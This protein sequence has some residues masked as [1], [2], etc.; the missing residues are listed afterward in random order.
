[1]VERKL[2]LSDINALKFL[3]IHLKIYLFVTPPLLNLG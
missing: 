2:R 1:M 3:Y